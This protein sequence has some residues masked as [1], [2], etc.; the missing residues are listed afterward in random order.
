MIFLHT[1]V[2]VFLTLNLLVIIVFYRETDIMYRV[3]KLN[4]PF[5]FLYFFLK[6]N[7]ILFPFSELS[8]VKI[9]PQRILLFNRRLSKYLP[10]NYFFISIMLKYFSFF[11]FHCFFFIFLFRLVYIFFSFL[12][13]ASFSYSLIV[14]RFTLFR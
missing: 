10:T 11:L 2:T 13:I 6:R 3:N 14:S 7:N 8:F 1:I 5:F 4:L 9:Y 12:Y